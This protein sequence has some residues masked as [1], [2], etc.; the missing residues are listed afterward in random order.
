MPLTRKQKAAIDALATTTTRTEAAEKLR[1]IRSE[2]EE[3]NNAFGHGQAV[4]SRVF[5]GIGFEDG[6]VKLG[7]DYEI[8][9]LTDV[10]EMPNEVA[11]RLE[12]E[13][14]KALEE[15]QGM[16]KAKGWDEPIDGDFDDLRPVL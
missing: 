8:H 7:F 1:E 3:V 6:N 10:K 9:K 14:E 11:R 13:R 2:A 4:I 15:Y 12:T 5:D 16:M